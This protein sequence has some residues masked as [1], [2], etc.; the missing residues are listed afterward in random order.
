MSFMQVVQNRKVQKK[1]NIKNSQK[2]CCI[3]ENGM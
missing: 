3:K 2:F 1:L